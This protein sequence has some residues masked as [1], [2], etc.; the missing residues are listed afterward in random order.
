MPMDRL[1]AETDCPYL[2]PEPVRGRRNDPSN[3]RYV[4]E[5]LAE[6]KGISLDE[7]CDINIKN[8][9]GLFGII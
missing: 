2:S 4:L 1:M 3:V 7:M 6:I 8:A 5:K 9:K